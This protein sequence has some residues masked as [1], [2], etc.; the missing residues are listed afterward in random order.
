MHDSSESK[1]CESVVRLVNTPDSAHVTST[2]TQSAGGAVRR[3][4]LLIDSNGVDDEK[5]LT[6]VQHK[7]EKYYR[8]TTNLADARRPRVHSCHTVHAHC[9]TLRTLFEWVSSQFV[10]LLAFSQSAWGQSISTP[11][12]SEW[13]FG[14]CISSVSN[15]EKPQ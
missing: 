11:F 1:V 6:G 4:R 5:Q 10:R 13:Q 7:D 8:T 15:K 14:P 2:P 3:S 9:N 12:T